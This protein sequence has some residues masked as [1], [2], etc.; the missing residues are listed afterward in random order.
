MCLGGNNL[1]NLQAKLENFWPRNN[2]DNNQHTSSPREKRGADLW[3]VIP[4]KRIDSF[5]RK[6]LLDNNISYNKT[7]L[8]DESVYFLA[9]ER[10]KIRSSDTS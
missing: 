4:C 8:I 10:D 7:V 5:L 6:D 2:I 9:T 1:E 3:L